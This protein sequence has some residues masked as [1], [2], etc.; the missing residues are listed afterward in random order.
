M[1]DRKSGSGQFPP[2]MGIIFM[3]V[4]AAIAVLSFLNY[5]QDGKISLTIV[6]GLLF[7]ALGALWYSHAKKSKSQGE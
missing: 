6:F 7:I 4:G 3:V 1:R 5:L 2:L